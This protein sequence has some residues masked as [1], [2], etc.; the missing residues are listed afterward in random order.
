MEDSSKTWKPSKKQE[1][2]LSLPDTIFEALYGGAAFGGKSEVLMMLPICREFIQHPRFKGIL[3]RRTYPELEK[4]LIIRSHFWYP[5]AGGKYND[6]KKRWQFPSGSIIQFG[7]AEHEAD[8]RKYDTTEY[9]YMAFDEVTSF[10]EFMY[11][12]LS[13]TRV[14]SSDEN[15]PAFVRSGTNPGNIGHNFFRTRFVDPC[16]S[17]GVVLRESRKIDGIMRSFNRIFI[18]SLATDNEVGMKNDPTYVFRLN[19]LPEAEKAA[20]LYGDWYTF[21]GQVFEDF[22]DGKDYQKFSDEPDTACHVI[23]PFEIPAYWPRVLS[24]DWGYAANNVAGEYAI[25]PYPSSKYPAT[26]YK[27]RETVRNKTKV[28]VWA[29]ELHDIYERENLS[30][31]DFVLD[32]SAWGNR[33]DEFTL[34]EQISEHLGITPRKADNDR[35]SGKILLQEML[36]WRVRPTLTSDEIYSSETAARISRTQG[37]KALKAYNDSFIPQEIDRFLPKFQIFKSCTETIKTIPLCVYAKDQKDG[38]PAED[39]AEFKG[40]DAY[41]ETRYGLKACQHYLDFGKQEYQKEQK[42]AQIEQAFE[43]S[44]DLTSYYIKMSSVQASERK[45]RTGF[46][47]GGRMGRMRRLLSR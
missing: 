45:E 16:H 17:G 4:E 39:V 32:P 25:N 28:S 3:F 36:R 34:V 14:R 6:Q 19:Q 30:F 42:I 40:D 24:I 35:I 9:N 15:L 27:Y 5:H 1:E 44:G 23:E 10:T 37:P 22:R 38:S 41:D 8:V 26:I 31:T 20:K 12:Y 47:S 29:K 2:F 13:F 11:L 21:E 7:Y 33:G 18:K 46:R 43:K